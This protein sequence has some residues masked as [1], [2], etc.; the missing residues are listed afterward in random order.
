[1]VLYF[2]VVVLLLQQ[3]LEHALLHAFHHFGT[4]RLQQSTIGTMNFLSTAAGALGLEM[5]PKQ[6]NN[7][8]LASRLEDFSSSCVWPLKITIENINHAQWNA[9]H[10]R[11]LSKQVKGASAWSLDTA[12]QV[13]RLLRKK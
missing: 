11:D 8:P 1:M 3:F 9:M 5:A 13:S 10:A 2:C 12:F 4:F 7:P 6:L